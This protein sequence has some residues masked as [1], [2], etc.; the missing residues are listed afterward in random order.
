MK[1]AVIMAFFHMSM[2]MACKGLNAIYFKRWS[3]FLFE[4]VTGF[5]VFWGL[6]GWLVFLSFYKWMF[7][8]VNNYA[9][10]DAKNPEF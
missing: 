6:I 3:V 8:P 10:N 2:G 1:M 7:Y 5:M 9:P 4:V